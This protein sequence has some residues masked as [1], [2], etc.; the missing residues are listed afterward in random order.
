MVWY[1]KS[2]GMGGSTE[3]VRV[4]EEKKNIYFEP[5]N[6]RTADKYVSLTA[7]QSYIPARDIS[8]WCAVYSTRLQLDKTQGRSEI[9]RC[10]YFSHSGHTPCGN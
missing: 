6:D 7:L 9:N 5:V 10:T 8:T 3:M 2:V 4:D 1:G